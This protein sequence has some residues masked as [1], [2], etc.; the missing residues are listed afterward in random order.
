MK[1]GTELN[2]SICATNVRLILGDDGNWNIDSLFYD[3]LDTLTKVSNIFDIYKRSETNTIN[4]AN[5]KFDDFDTIV[6]D[7]K[8]LIIC[9]SEMN[10]ELVLDDDN[11]W[12]L[13]SLELYSED[14][15]STL[16]HILRV[17]DINIASKIS[18]RDELDDILKKFEIAMA[19]TGELDDILKKFQIAMTDGIE[20]NINI[21]SMDAQLVLDD[22]DGWI[23]HAINC[24]SKYELF[25]IC[26]I[27]NLLGINVGTEINSLDEIPDF[28][29][30][31]MM[32]GK[33]LRIQTNEIDA[34]LIIG[35]DN[36][37]ITDF[38][39]TSSD[40]TPLYDIL[41]ILGINIKFDIET[42]N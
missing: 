34:C 36:W 13:Q 42:D 31:Y 17:L 7:E 22:D 1:E 40:G 41:R 23:I 14:N 20:L 29:T 35:D 19:H 9:I 2:I 30:I 21:S 37:Y 12:I 4:N 5:D 28:T 33:C 15:L 8:E 24:H 27:L 6:M 26:C 16:C 25:Q 32:Y 3:S 18:T 38:I 10:V 11:N 39:S